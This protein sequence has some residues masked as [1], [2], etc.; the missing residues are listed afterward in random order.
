VL[1]DAE[2]VARDLQATRSPG[3]ATIEQLDG[4]TAS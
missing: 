2:A 3:I 4:S 1:L